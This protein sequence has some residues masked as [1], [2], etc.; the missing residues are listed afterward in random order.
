MSILPLLNSCFLCII[1]KI[2]INLNFDFV[3]KYV[4]LWYTQ[5]KLT[6]NHILIPAVVL[7]SY[8]SFLEFTP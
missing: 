3:I 2:S 6:L 1:H 8:V 7:Q 4:Y 5:P